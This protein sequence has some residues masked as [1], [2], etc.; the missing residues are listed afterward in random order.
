[1]AEEKLYTREEVESLLDERDRKLEE[2]LRDFIAK[3]SSDTD[4]GG[5]KDEENIRLESSTLHQE[6]HQAF[7]IDDERSLMNLPLLPLDTFSFLAFVKLKSTSML[8]TIIVLAVQ[9]TTLSLLSFDEFSTGDSGNIFGVPPQVSSATSIIQVLALFIGVFSQSDFSDS[10]NSLLIGYDKEELEFYFGP[11]IFYWR[12]LVAHWT[13]IVVSSFGLFTTF[14]LIVSESDPTD[15]LLD[16]T[17][18]EFITNLDNIF[19]WLSA[20]GYMG[21]KAQQ[22]ATLVATADPCYLVVMKSKG[23]FSGEDEGPAGR[24][25]RSSSKSLGVLTT[26]KSSR[27]LGQRST[28]IDVSPKDR[29]HGRD[30]VRTMEKTVD[31]EESQNPRLKERRDFRLFF[32]LLM[33]SFCLIGWGFIFYNQLGG[34]YLCQNIFVQFHDDIAPE[35][36]SFS[37]IYEFGCI[38]KSCS[39]AQYVEVGSGKNRNTARFGFCEE[40]NAWVFTF[41]DQPTD[42]PPLC[43]WKAKSEGVDPLSAEAYDLLTT[44]K[45]DWYNLNE[46]QVE[47]PMTDISMKCIDCNNNSFC[48]FHGTC[49]SNRCVCDEGWQG[50]RCEFKAPCRSL[51]VVDLSIP[52]YEDDTYAYGLNFETM[53]I[54]AERA[55]DTWVE[56]Y[57]RP[58]YYTR[59]EKPVVVTIFNGRRWV[60]GR[61]GL[62]PGQVDEENNDTAPFE[63]FHGYWSMYTVDFVSE[64]VDVDTPWDSNDPASLNW[65]K[66]ELQ[67]ED[68]IQAVNKNSPI[69]AKLLC[70]YCDNETNPC[71]FNGIC[72]D[73][74]TCECVNGATG[75]LCQIKPISNGFCDLAFNTAQEAFDG[76][77]CCE[78]TCQNTSEYVCGMETIKNGTESTLV[79]IGFPNC[80][81]PRQ[82]KP[83]TPANN[84]G[85]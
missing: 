38:E 42:V 77:D 79:Y 31:V 11:N 14:L 21:L 59:E 7:G 35:M 27:R 55:S 69:D 15:L 54:D 74:G 32:L 80:S 45:Q 36:A 52:F 48:G 2:R 46:R 6:Q 26:D 16:F 8:S 78:G 51:Q 20:W 70:S 82:Q 37:G 25:S 3:S 1:M 10:L 19:F 18:I 41:G 9:M 49:E 85:E 30:R 67:L 23:G 12:W 81:D 22:D 17:A 62:F 76:G 5:D 64:A 4:E 83:S 24:I 13:R 34:K 84:T 43:Q 65:F 71:N 63:N 60:M 53:K 29:K 28:R 75:A 56:V 72:Q 68:E 39:R 73:D 58:I 66:P 50:I 40:E 61:I 47:V 33:Y 44:A 57:G